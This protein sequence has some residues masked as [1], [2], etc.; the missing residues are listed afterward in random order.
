MVSAFSRCSSGA[1]V[2]PMNTIL[3]FDVSLLHFPGGDVEFTGWFYPVA[4]YS[5]RYL[6]SLLDNFFRGVP[7]PFLEDTTAAVLQRPT[8]QGPLRSWT[9]ILLLH[10]HSSPS[11]TMSLRRLLIQAPPFF[12]VAIS[13]LFC[14]CPALF[15]LSPCPQVCRS[16]RQFVPLHRKILFLE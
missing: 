7:L 14:P 1:D 6:F 5:C 3:K 15:A 12:G 10:V 11:L 8:P 4:T 9:M 2:F 13:S 16:P